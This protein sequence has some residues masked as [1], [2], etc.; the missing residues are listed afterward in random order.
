MTKL[1][2]GMAAVLALLSGACSDDGGETNSAAGGAGGTGGSGG[3]AGAGGSAGS[4][5][6]P[7]CVG[8]ESTDENFSQALQ[9][10]RD[11]LDA[12]KVP[13]GAIA[14][15][16]DGK[17][18]N[19]GVAGSKRGLLCDPITPDTLF[20]QQFATELITS[21]ATLDAVEDGKLSLTDPIKPVAPT[22]SVTHG[23]V[24]QITLHH[25]LTGSAMYYA[26]SIDGSIEAENGPAWDIGSECMDNLA[27]A[28]ANAK[29]PVIQATPGSMNNHLN[30]NFELAGLALEN[31][32]KKPFADAVKA[33]VLGPLAMGG[34][35]DKASI[36]ASDHSI[37][38]E[39]GQIEDGLHADCRNRD[40]SEGYHGS[41]RDMAKLAEYLTGG[42]GQ[43]LEPTML[44]AMLSEQ[45]VHFTS[46][47]YT[48]YG[49]DGYRA[50]AIQDDVVWASGWGWGFST[51]FTIYR[52]RGLVV[53]TLMNAQNGDPA[54]VSTAV[55][56]IYDPS[57]EQEEFPQKAYTPDLASLSTL[58]GKYEDNLGFKGIT[59]RTLDVSLDSGNKLVGTLSASDSPSAEPVSFEGAYGA[60]NFEL[61]VPPNTYLARFWRDDAGNA[62][63]ISLVGKYGPPFFLAP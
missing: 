17:L 26:D 43:I 52:Q 18:L 14:I 47:A 41:I 38:H 62:Y 57:L 36:E 33:R 6:A 23:D 61:T 24:Q 32:D 31:V 1:G 13:G 60:D 21:I 63:A 44:D 2:L 9:V 45:G 15:I 5:G 37:G 48:F 22:L 50:D 27:D 25:L 35:F 12:Q 54:A 56:R 4:A 10:L 28:F 8:T 49:G 42:A 20:R 59:Q 46:F 55:A 58:V 39:A 51:D 11:A 53:I 16:K 40:P 3:Q 19:L 34:A 30:N 7:S 29:N